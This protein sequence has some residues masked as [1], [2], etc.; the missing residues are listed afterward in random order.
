M[1]PTS[2]RI[3]TISR[4]M[5]MVMEDSFQKSEI[6]AEAAPESQ[7]AAGQVTAPADWLRLPLQ[8]FLLC[9]Q[10]ELD[11]G[12]GWL[13]LALPFPVGT[14]PDVLLGKRPAVVG[15]VAISS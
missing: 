11:G 10:P 8:K 5:P 2:I 1:A 3:R 6:Q 9:F 7:A 15:L 4:I 14:Q 12:L 13:P